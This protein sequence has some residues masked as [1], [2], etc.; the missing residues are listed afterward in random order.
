[1]AADERQQR[2]Q[3]RPAFLS[4]QRKAQRMEQRLPLASGRG[5]DV[6]RPGGPGGF[7]PGLLGEKLRR[8]PQECRVLANRL[9]FAGLFSWEWLPGFPCSSSMNYLC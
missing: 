6:A 4:R 5:L 8:F 1:V 3:L 7:V 9:D 2:G